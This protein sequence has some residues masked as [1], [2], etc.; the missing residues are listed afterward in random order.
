MLGPAWPEPEE[1]EGLGQGRVEGEVGALGGWRVWLAGARCV[2]EGVVVVVG[3]RVW[4][5]VR[6]GAGM[7]GEGVRRVVRGVKGG[8]RNRGA[9]G[10]MIR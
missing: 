6:G 3:W 1:G 4:R 7:V 8:G 2:P 9:G 5:G 10:F